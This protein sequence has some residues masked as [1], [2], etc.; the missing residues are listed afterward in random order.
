MLNIV[1]A[2]ALVGS[3]GILGLAAA[4][5]IS[6]VVCAL[7]AL[8]VMSYKVPGFPLRPI[9]ASLW[10]MLVAGAVAGEATWLVASR[11]G[12]D[13]GLAAV[14]RLVVGGV[15]GG[16][17]YVGVLLALRAPELTAVR[18]RLPGRHRSPVL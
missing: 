14:V 10:R 1:L 3:Y 5:A 6:Y 17:V 18:S 12:D 9:M 11:V 13:A 15:V 8:Q 2:F 16:L 7:W 4:L